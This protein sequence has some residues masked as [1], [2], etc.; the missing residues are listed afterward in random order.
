ME[1]TTE[2]DRKLQFSPL[3]WKPERVLPV[4]AKAETAAYYRKRSCQLLK[5]FCYRLL[6]ATLCL[7]FARF[8]TGVREDHYESRA[9]NYKTRKL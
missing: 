5:L 4:Q 2:R 9:N 1:I 3:N 6:L 7:T 8:H